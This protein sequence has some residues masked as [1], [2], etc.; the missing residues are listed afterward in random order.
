MAGRARLQRAAWM[1]KCDIFCEG[2]EGISGEHDRIY[3]CFFHGT[4]RPSEI[5]LLEDL[6]GLKQSNIIDNRYIMIY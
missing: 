1:Q 3:G 2:H 4:E 5:D 6:D